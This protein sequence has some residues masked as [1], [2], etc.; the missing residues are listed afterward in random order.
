MAEWLGHH[1]LYMSNTVDLIQPQKRH[2]SIGTDGQLFVQKHVFH[3]L[4]ML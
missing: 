3:G 2:L 4:C 1:T